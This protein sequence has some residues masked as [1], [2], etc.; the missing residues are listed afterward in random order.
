MRWQWKRWI[1]PVT[2]LL[3][4]AA[5]AWQFDA[6][7]HQAG[8][9]AQLNAE[10]AALRQRLVNLSQAPAVAARLTTP[11][12]PA[13]ERSGGTGSKQERNPEDA[14]TIQNLSS[15]LAEATASA[16]RLQS[17][18][19][20]AEAEVQRLT[21]DNRR[22]TSSET[23]L[24]QNLAALK[25]RVN[26]LQ[27]E[28]KSSHESVVRMETAGHQAETRYQELRD[29]SAADSQKLAEIRALAAQL[30][31]I[32]KRREVSLNGIL[33]RYKQITEQYRSLSGVL[34][35]Q[36]TGTPS[37]G[38]GD[39]ARIQDSIALAEEDLRQLDNLNAQALLI[40]KKM[41]AK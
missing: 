14:L 29:Q 21:L 33:R 4:L 24:H 18:A 27:E 31:D 25:Q 15:G 32:H 2:A 5:V 34:Q 16:A 7:R 35:E 9:L 8:R 41:A 36:H 6:N 12:L 13:E 11:E 23:D 1:W 22:L 19:D 3:V 17:R 20:Q 37:V 39:L 10:N 38:S 30:Q 40:Q 28:L 26:E